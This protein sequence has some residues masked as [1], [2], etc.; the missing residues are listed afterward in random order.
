MSEDGIKMDLWLN[1]VNGLK[2]NGISCL[3][4][5][6]EGSFCRCPVYLLRFSILPDLLDEFLHLLTIIV[7]VLTLKLTV[8]CDLRASIL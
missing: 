7:L 4:M 3:L 5:L 2:F 1:L 6:I 8:L